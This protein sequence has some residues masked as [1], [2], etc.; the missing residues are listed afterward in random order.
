[1]KEGLDIVR[2]KV[3][4]LTSKVGVVLIPIMLTVE[5]LLLLYG[6]SPYMPKEASHVSDICMLSL[7]KGQNYNFKSEECQSNNKRKIYPI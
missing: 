6:C 7:T 5:K 4:A 2:T 3:Q 1:M